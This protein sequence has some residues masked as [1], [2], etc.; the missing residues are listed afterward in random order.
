MALTDTQIRNTKPAD[1][2]LKLT[3]G[4][5]LY[6]E[7]TPAGGKLWRSA[8][9]PPRNVGLEKC[10]PI[11]NRRGFFLKAH[12]PHGRRCRRGLAGLQAAPRRQSGGGDRGYVRSPKRT[13]AYSMLSDRARQLAS[14]MLALAPTVVQPSSPLWKSMSTRVLAE[15]PLVPARIRTL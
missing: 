15:V 6:L 8:R 9:R 14:M 7:V 10:L 2:P 5:G 3:D 13:N 12:G 1:K 4:R 11:R